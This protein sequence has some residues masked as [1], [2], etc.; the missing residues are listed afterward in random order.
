MPLR[1]QH[2]TAASAPGLIGGAEWDADHAITGTLDDAAFPAVLPSSSA[3]HLTDTPLGEASAPA[4]VASPRVTK[5]LDPLASGWARSSTVGTVTNE[6]G[7]G[8]YGTG[9]ALKLTTVDAQ[10]VAAQPSAYSPAL[11][12]TGQTVAIWVKL[13]D[14]TTITECLLYL[15]SDN[16]VGY[17]VWNLDTLP[18]TKAF[19]LPNEWSRV[20][21]SLA[22]ATTVGTVDLSAI[23]RA[24]LRISAQGAG[25]SAWFSS[26]AICEHPATAGAVSITFDDSLKSQYLTALPMMDAYGFPGTCYNIIS[27]IDSASAY[28]LAQAK[29][30]V[31]LHGWEMAAHAWSLDYHPPGTV[32]TAATDAELRSNFRQMRRWLTEQGFG[33]GADHYAYPQGAFDRRV[34]DMSRQYF[35][36]ART[37]TGTTANVGVGETWPPADP[38][39]LRVLPTDNT[40]TTAAINTAIDKAVSGKHWLILVFHDIVATATL[41]TH[42][43]TAS[44]ATVLSHLASTGVPVRTVGDVC[45]R[46]L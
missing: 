15:T 42:Y 22:N 37:V 45:Q 17:V 21:L 3:I 35:S 19:L 2:A 16:F 10:N 1:I 14:P 28:S 41:S 39:R 38:F 24:R 20:T 7:A 9:T 44:F 36:S 25:A 34:L 32:N 29:D 23:T 26:L 31:R 27:Q 6:A 43:A 5:V 13:S 33:P 40:T 4:W 46:G 30:M 11:D 8:G 18:Y 12:L